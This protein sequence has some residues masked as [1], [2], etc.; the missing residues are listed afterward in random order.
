MSIKVKSNNKELVYSNK[1]TNE[2]VSAL[3]R[4]CK[5]AVTSLSTASSGVNLNPTQVSRSTSL[6][7]NNNTNLVKAL[8]Q[9]MYD[10]G[11]INKATYEKVIQKL[12]KEVEKHDRTKR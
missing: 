9:I 11:E 8:I 1:K 4:K 3:D 2:D 6:K 7:K 10:R 12:M 5:E